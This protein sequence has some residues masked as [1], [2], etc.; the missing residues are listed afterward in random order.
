MTLTRIKWL[1]KEKEWNRCVL[2]C[3][4]RHSS[5]YKR[6]FMSF[7]KVK[8]HH[9]NICIYIYIW[10]VMGHD[11]WRPRVIPQ[12]KRNHYLLAIYYMLATCVTAKHKNKNKI[13]NPHLTSSSNDTSLTLR[14]QKGKSGQSRGNQQHKPMPRKHKSAN[15]KGITPS[16][17]K[18]WAM[19]L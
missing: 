11:E 12:F 13:N 6:V 15:C 4:V 8:N 7:G 2:M 9:I 10:T 3:N 19:R 18:C 5:K 14:S 1:L 16:R 17:Q